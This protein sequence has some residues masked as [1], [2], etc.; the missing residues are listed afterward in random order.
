MSDTSTRHDGTSHDHGVSEFRSRALGPVVMFFAILIVMAIAIGGFAR[1]LLQVDKQGA[2]VLAGI[3]AAGILGSVALAAS[4]D[5]LDG[6]RKAIAALPAVLPLLIGVVFALPATDLIDEAARNINRE[7]IEVGIPFP[8]DT[9]VT[10]VAANSI[11]FET[12]SITLPTG[13][14]VGI[15][16]DN[17]E[18]GVQHNIW[19]AP[20]VDN[21]SSE[22]VFQGANVT[23]PNSVEYA[24]DAPAD[25]GSFA[26]WCSIHPNM[27][28]TVDFAADAEPAAS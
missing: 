22:L 14:V 21:N 17:Q 10:V 23:G 5:K 2:L 8:E 1:I 18:A 9:S 20:E 6:P 28:G 12:T 13:Q 26:F 3:V 11:E 15:L 19:I 4:Q 16:F 25:D 27:V 7:V 24:F